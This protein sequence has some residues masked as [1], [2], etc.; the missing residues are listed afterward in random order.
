MSKN[1]NVFRNKRSILFNNFLGGIA[2]SIGVWIGTTII[3]GL[4][5]F[6]LSKVNLVPVVGNF[7]SEVTKYVETDEKFFPFKLEAK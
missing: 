6:F 2:W 3:L 7:V 5:L 4:S 1:E